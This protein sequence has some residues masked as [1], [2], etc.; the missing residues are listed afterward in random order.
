VTEGESPPLIGKVEPVSCVSP[1]HSSSDRMNS[2]IQKEA[3]KLVIP[4][5]IE[6]TRKSNLD[7]LIE[8]DGQEVE[9]VN[10]IQMKVRSDRVV[11]DILNPQRSNSGIYK[12]IL[13]N[14]QGSCEVDVPVEVLDIP[15]PPLSVSVQEVRKNSVIIQWKAPEDDGGSPIKHFVTEILNFTTNNIWSSVAMT[16]TGDCLEQEVDHLLEGHRYIFRVAAVNRLGQSETQ[17][18]RGEIITK[19]PWDAPSPCGKPQIL[20]WTPT[21]VDLSWTSPFSDGGSPISSFIIEVR[22]SSMKQW[23]DGGVIPIE[24]IEYDGDRCRGRCENLE[25]EY[26]YK[27]RVIAVNRAGKSSPG[28]AS[29]SVIAMHKYV[30]PYIKV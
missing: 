7:I 16:D 20:D 21:F 13:S 12:V 5:K 30:S 1:L 18:T 2:Y 26:E 9:I 23:I 3:C 15:S 22:E 8:K 19:D 6:G 27:F 24:D 17:E 4:Y 14:D 29:E 25:E 28:S 11:I 10:D